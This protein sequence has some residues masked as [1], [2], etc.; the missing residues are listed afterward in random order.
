MI[1]CVVCLFCVFAVGFD[2]RTER[3]YFVKADSSTRPHSP[4]NCLGHGS[5]I[6]AYLRNGSP[7]RTLPGC[8]KNS[9][10]KVEIGLSLGSCCLLEARSKPEHQHLTLQKGRQRCHPHTKKHKG[11]LKWGM[12]RGLFGIAK[13]KPRMNNR[14]RLDGESHLRGNSD[15]G[16]SNPGLAKTP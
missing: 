6:K 11:G 5:E 1:F 4:L 14:F 8:F 7:Q 10:A 13:W 2:W 12:E 16:A 9:G 3:P 15:D